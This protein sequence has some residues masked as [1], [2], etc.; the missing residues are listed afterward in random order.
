MLLVLMLPIFTSH[1]LKSCVQWSRMLG[2]PVLMLH[3]PRVLGLRSA[4]VMHVNVACGSCVPKVVCAVSCCSWSFN[5][6]TTHKGWFQQTK[7]LMEFSIKLAGWVLNA[8]FSIKKKE[9]NMVLKHLICMKSI[10]NQT[11]FFHIMT[12]PNQPHH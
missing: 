6:T 3:V 12:P 7:K 4:M 10:L 8:P 5:K 11:C 1:V 9:N 2:S